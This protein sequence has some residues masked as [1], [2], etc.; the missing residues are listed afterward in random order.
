MVP[1]RDIQENRLYGQFLDDMKSE[2]SIFEACLHAIKDILRRK[3]SGGRLL[4][5]DRSGTKM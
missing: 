3:S 5:A 2:Q 1:F 4:C